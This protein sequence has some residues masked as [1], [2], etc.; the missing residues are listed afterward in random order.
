MSRRPVRIKT[1]NLEEGMPTVAQA[2]LRMEREL[3]VARQEKCVAVKLIHGY[4]SSGA[5]GVLRIE[6]QKD[7]RKLADHGTIKAFVAGENWRKSDEMTWEL[8]K[9]F[10]EWKSDHD[11][12]RGNLGISVVVL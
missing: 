5:G 2:R 10:P 1:V 4:G 9:R 11:L 3:Q 8:L 6:L 12:G 7:L